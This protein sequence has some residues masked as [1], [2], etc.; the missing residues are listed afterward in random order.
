MSFQAELKFDTSEP[1]SERETIDTFLDEIINFDDFGKITEAFP[2]ECLNGNIHSY[3]NVYTNEFWT[4]KQRAAHSLHEISYR[5]CFKPQLPRFFIERFTLPGD[6]VYDPFMG[7]GTTLVEA[8]LM[9]RIPYGCDVNPLCQIFV[10]PRLSPPSLSDIEKRLRIID[11]NCI[12]EYP[13][14]LHVF[15]HPQTLSRICALRQYLLRRREE[16]RFDYI[17]GWIQMVALNR[18]TGHSPGFF[19]VYTLPPNQAVSVQS[20]KKINERLKQAP[21]FRDVHKI[22]IK[23][24]KAL[25]SDYNLWNEQSLSKIINKITLLSQSCSSTPEIPDNSVQ[26][27]VTSPPFLN[28]VNYSADNWLRAWFC[29]TPA[30]PDQ[31]W[32]LKNISDWEA[33]MTAALSECCRVLK[34]GGLVAFE[35]GEVRNATIHLDELAILCGSKAGLRPVCILINKQNFTKTAN[36]WGVQNGEKGT[37]TNRI[38][39][40]QKSALLS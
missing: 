21:P 1:L 26:L 3:I 12:N 27:I 22:I 7:R 2:F 38:A 19:S 8:A 24:S 31:L 16:S 30:S 15:Y 25:L 35:V 33:A 14:E 4:A 5:A 40:F 39:I 20:Q 13:E 28:I 6:V 9:G 36:C 18:L 32:S 11:F 34:P 10:R 29:A 17:D 37:N 23:K